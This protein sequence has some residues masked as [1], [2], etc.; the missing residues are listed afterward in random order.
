MI[1]THTC[2]VCG[3]PW[4]DERQRSSGAGGSYEIC[5]CCGFQPGYTDDDRGFSVEGWRRRWIGSGMLFRSADDELPPPGWDPAAQLEVLLTWEVPPLPDLPDSSLLRGVLEMGNLP[6]VVQLLSTSTV[7]VALAG[8]VA[9]NGSVV[10]EKTGHH[11][12]MLVFTGPQQWHAWA[13]APGMPPFPGAATSLRTRRPSAR[14][15]WWST[16]A[17]PRRCSSPWSSSAS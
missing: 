15:S 3:W 1:L 4:L 17:A 8:P 7:L 11:T 13:N 2:A 12:E 5:V 16:S 6:W 10:L 14:I 9:D